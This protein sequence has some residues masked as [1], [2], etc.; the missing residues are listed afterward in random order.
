MIRENRQTYKPYNKQRKI[1]ILSIATFPGLNRCKQ[2]NQT[3]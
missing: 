3:R 2:L 1:T